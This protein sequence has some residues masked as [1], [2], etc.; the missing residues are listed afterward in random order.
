MTEVRYNNQSGSLGASLTNSGTTITFATAPDFATLSGGQTITLAL[1]PGTSNY[2]IVYLTA[3][4]AGTTTGTI[5]RAAEDGTNWP[6]VAHNS[7]VAWAC[8]PT[9]NDFTSGGGSG[10]VTSVSVATANGYSG[11]VA[12]P[13]TT[14][15]I[16]LTGPSTLPPS[17]T[18][19]GDLTGTYPVPTLASTAVTAGSY[20]STN[21]TVDAKGRVT[22]AANGSAGLTPTVYSFD[23]TISAPNQLAIAS[24]SSALNLSLPASP[25][26]KD[27]VVVLNGLTTFAAA[28]TVTAN[29]GQSVA[30]VRG[31]STSSITVPRPGESVSLVYKASNGWWYPQADPDPSIAGDVTGTPSASTVAK[32]NGSPIGTVTGAT[33]NDVLTWNGS[34]WVNQTPS[35]GGISALTGDVTASG[36]GSVA[37]T[38]AAA[39]TSGTYG[40]ATAVPVFTTDTK[41]RVTGVTNTTITGVPVANITGAAPLASPTFTGTVTVPNGSALGT[42][43]TLTLTNATGLP[44][45]GV[46]NLTTDLAYVQAASR[47]TLSANFG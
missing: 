30:G 47:I 40:S 28:V 45:A 33:T 10:T 14:P 43:T 31:G 2:E 12:N 26:D 16:T 18:A 38:L 13:T 35:S 3:Y 19:G 25:S 11:T 34:A 20:T 8:A 42:P 41:G 7:G 23:T 46:T 29:T 22:A 9:V 6:A 17:G 5:S 27:A 44:E 4:T 1:E 36:S 37:A 32:I 24:G 15:A 21:L 39:G